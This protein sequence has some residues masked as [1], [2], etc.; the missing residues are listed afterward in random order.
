VT[1]HLSTATLKD[2]PQ[3]VRRP[4]YDRGNVEPGIVHIGPGAFHRVHQA[5]YA[6]QW[7]ATDPRWGINAVSLRSSTLRDALQAQDWLYALAILDEHESFEVIGSLCG[8]Q[9]AG[10]S[11]HVVSSSI[12]SPATRLVTLTVTEK[13]Y[14]LDG[15]SRLDL[16]HADI[17]HDLEHP[18]SPR[19]AIGLLVEGLRLRRARQLPAVPVLSCDNLASNGRLLAAAAREFAAQ[20]DPG[21]AAWI[22]AEVAFPCTMVDSITPATTPALVQRV[23]MELGME[24]R[25]PVQRESFV[26]W[27][28][29]EHEALESPDWARAGVTLTDDVSGYER[30]KLRLLNGAHSTLAYVGIL[31]GHQTVADAMR[32]T[33]LSAFVRDLMRKDVAPTLRPVRGLDIDGY[34]EAVLRRFANPSIHHELAQIA[35]DGSKKLPIRIIG[36]IQDALANGAPIERPCVTLAAWMHFVRRRTAEAV[37]LVDPLSERLACLARERTTGD[38]TNDV[39]AFLSLHEMLPRD[40]AEDVRLRKALERAYGKLATAPGNLVT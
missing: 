15:G 27:V 2:L 1:R 39:G 5:W 22:E 16:Q 4:R 28:V 26:Q 17:R 32:D 3:G 33:A 34:I 13:G 14:C 31:R 10:E 18:E 35:W 23:T 9:V 6:E 19:S 7:L 25:W 38:T 20:L 12:A 30:A 40:L 24:D 29:E 36:T 21:L 8:V 37:A 11:P